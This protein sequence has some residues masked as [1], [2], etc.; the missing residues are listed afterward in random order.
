MEQLIDALGG[1]TALAKALNLTP[2][3]VSNWRNRGIPWKLRP[4]IARMANEKAV[5]L[6]SDFWGE[7]A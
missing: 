2:N 3:A 1:N 6:P 5:P 4:Q 7:A